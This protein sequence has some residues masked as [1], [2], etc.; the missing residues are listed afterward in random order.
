M[1]DPRTQQ[2]QS[3]AAQSPEAYAQPAQ[4]EAAYQPA[5][6]PPSAFEVAARVARLLFRRLLYL[7]DALWRLVSPRL[8]WILVT[9]FLIGLVGLLS[10]LLVLPRIVR[11]GPASD[12]RVAMISPAASVVDFLRGQQTYDADLMWESFS[13][14]FRAALEEREI[15]REAL[16]Q[17][18]ESE[19]R[20]GQRYREAQ[21]VGGVELDDRQTMYFYAVEVVSPTPERNGTFSFV[22]VVDRD[23]KIVSV[24][25]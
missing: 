19:R 7:I 3:T 1:E 10:L 8:G 24:R 18:A 15:T 20:A 12:S 17:Q 22:F 25:M 14:D 6:S 2:A 16:A 4:A 9:S 5:Q 13:P 11:T 21:Y 23:G